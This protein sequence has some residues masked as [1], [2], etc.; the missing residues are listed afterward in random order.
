MRIGICDDLEKE[1]RVTEEWCRKY[2][3]EHYLDAELLCAA[4]WNALSGEELDLLLLDVEMPGKDGISIKEQL[5]EGDRPFIIFVTS[6]DEYMPSAFG[7]NVI[8]FVC[9]PIEEYDIYMSL[10]KALHLL[11]AGKKVIFDDGFSISSECIQYFAADRGYSKAVLSDGREKKYQHRTLAAWER[12]MEEVYF[13]RIT[14][15]QL[16]NS[17]FICDFTADMIVLANGERLKVSKRRRTDCMR[18]FM[19]YVQKYGAYI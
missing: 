4:D 14:H 15:S 9:K 17:R 1:L 7:K 18:R 2:L 5:C 8:G 3:D 10:E 12:E 16:V 6:Y 13:L 11:C 19:E